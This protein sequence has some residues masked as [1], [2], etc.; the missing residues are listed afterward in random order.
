MNVLDLI[1]AAILLICVIIC[2][3]KGLLISLFN[4]FSLLISF[5][6]TRRLYPTVSDFLRE[7]PLF[8]SLK[9]IILGWIGRGDITSDTGQI[10]TDTVN[11][12]A[13]PELFKRLVLENIDS[14]TLDLTG[15]YDAVADFGAGLAMDALAIAG[16]F[17][18]VFL[19]M[20]IIAMVLKI[21][22]RMPVIKTFNRIG[23][24]VMGLVIGSLLSWLILSVMRGLFYANADFP[25][26]DMLAESLLARFFMFNL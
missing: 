17:L 20:R 12:M 21:I 18:T 11:S 8:Y 22:S 13:L 14:Q 1:T 5:L 9:E 2:A 6:L 23:G 7:T 25:V 24:A 10:V 26:A 3:A 15:V 16:V 4:L 19:L